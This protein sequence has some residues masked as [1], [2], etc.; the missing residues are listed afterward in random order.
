MARMGWT[1]WDL[2]GKRCGKFGDGPRDLEMV[3]AGAGYRTMAFGD[4]REVFAHFH[5]ETGS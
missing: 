2:S 5:S 4:D 3:D 1:R